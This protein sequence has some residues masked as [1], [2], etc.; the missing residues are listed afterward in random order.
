MSASWPLP[1]SA[2]K[3][4]IEGQPG[5]AENVTGIGVAMPNQ[6]WQWRWAFE[7]EAAG[8]LDRWQTIDLGS[9]IE[10]VLKCPAYIANDASSAAAAELVF[11]Q[12]RHYSNFI[13]VYIGAMI[14]GGIVLDGNLVTGPQGNAGAIGPILISTPDGPAQLI[15]RASLFR[16][17]DFFRRADL[18][19]TPLWSNPDRWPDFSAVYDLWIAECAPALAQAI[20][21]AR[22][23]FDF[24]VAIIDGAMPTTMRTQVLD[25]VHTEIVGLNQTGLSPAAWS[26]AAWGASPDRSA[27]PAS[28]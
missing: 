16:L 19:P 5:W 28:R 25:A 9:E 4:L 15:D 7:A 13:Y 23:V 17:E 6:I 3:T 27:A 26:R 2:A 11:G 22:A 12:G 18:D 1:E 14:G 8:A 10:A 24:E 20:V 21:C